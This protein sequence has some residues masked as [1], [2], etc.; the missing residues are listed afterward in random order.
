MTLAR[1]CSVLLC[2]AIA[3]C[4]AAEELGPVESHGFNARIKAARDRN[5]AWVDRPIQI[6]LLFVEDRGGAAIARR[7]Q[8]VLEKNTTD[9]DVDV[10]V[11]IER[12]G[13]SDDSVAGDKY[14]IA[15]KAYPD[16]GWRIESARFGWRCWDGRGHTHYSQEP[17]I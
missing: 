16:E 11:T 5:E 7:E 3:A 4:G 12:F 10:T 6:S 8:I 14:A 9:P 13:F 2:G 17:C 15:L 1:I